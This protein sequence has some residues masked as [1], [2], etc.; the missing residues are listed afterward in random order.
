MPGDNRAAEAMKVPAVRVCL[1]PVIEDPRGS[2]SYAE[3]GELLP[4]V[5]RRYFIVFDVPQGQTRGGH[6][7]RT[8]E[9][10][11]VCVKGRVTVTVEDGR[12]RDEVL[13]DSPRLGL[14]IPPLIWAT[15]QYHSPDAVF[16]ALSSDVYDANE[17]IT[18]YGEFLK[19]TEQR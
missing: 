10:F 3:Y 7:H 13:L 14:Y 4:F 5:S 12:N 18:D 6:A 16:L 8:V 17:Y 9:Q 2:L 11:L 15:Q 19:I 1:L